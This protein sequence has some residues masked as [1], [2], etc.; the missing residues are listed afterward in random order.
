MA[1]KHVVLVFGYGCHLVPELEE[2]LDRVVVF[3]RLLKPDLV[4]FCGGFTQRKTAP[5]MSEARLMAGYVLPPL[6]Q[7][8]LPTQ[9]PFL[10]EEDSYTTPD[11]AEKASQINYPGLLSKE[12]KLTVFCEATRALK[13][14]LL[15]RHFFGRRANIETAS[16]ELMSPS[17]QILSTVYD[18]AAIKFP[19]LA[20]YWRNK[21]IERSYHI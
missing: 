15:I 5:G 18:L 21:R 4:V 1:Q 8:L 2:Y 12:T 3:C 9:L 13:V 10:L 20:R 7:V 14:D 6:D 16:W 19:S 11:N 17:K